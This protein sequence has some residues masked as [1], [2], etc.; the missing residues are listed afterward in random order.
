MK[1]EF[2]NTVALVKPDN[3]GEAEV[4]GQVRDKVKTAVPSARY[5][6]QHKLWLRTKGKQGWDGKTSILSKP[7]PSNRSA[8]FPTGLLPMVH[9]EL[10]ERMNGVI[11][12]KDL[13]VVPPGMDMNPTY[14]VPLRDYQQG[15]ISPAMSNVVVMGEMEHYWPCGVLKIATGGGKTEIAVA[16]YEAQPLPSV[17]VVHRKHLITQA[18]DRF[19]KYGIPSG[20]IGDS[21][22]E[23][24]PTGITVATI[25]TLHKVLKDGDMSKIRQFIKAQQIWFDEAHLCASKVDKGNQFVT[26]A[27]QFRH[28][29]FRW[30][31]T[32]TPFMKDKY[33]NQLLMGCTGDLLCEISNDFLIK[34]GY[35]T[36][37]LVKIIDT[38]DVVG[39]K[40]WPEVY[41]SAIVLNRPRN[42]RIIEE[43]AA[44]PK[45]AI[46]M[47]TRLGHARVLHRMAK[48]KG[49][50]LP[51][52]QCGDTKNKDRT[53]MI[54]D[55]QSGREKAIIAT[56][57]YDDGLDIPE[58]R[59]LIFAGGGKSTVASL[60]RIGRG[61]RLA[62]GKH[63]VLVIDFNDTSGT[64]MKRHSA[65]RRKVWRDEG[66]TIEEVT[67]DDHT[68]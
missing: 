32:A 19:A 53:Q 40:Q 15:A 49:I 27:R 66:F 68:K 38:P 54:K 5:M 17:F 51:A 20:Q 2:D 8:F 12:F 41:E 6:Y 64:I 42:L 7:H 67:A 48:D 35:L 60:Q 50:Q 23:P 28:A 25:Q 3:E 9:D 58:L 10:M 39:P 62:A 36:P 18:R 46:V 57:I 43:L 1:I 61:L 56:T 33:S 24:S 59:T 52:I 22:F 37:P 63:E 16:M 21:V 34:A 26:L 14:T 65:A 29:Y 30:G 31:L 45:P 55:L 47:C 44:C 13:R 4:Y 11:Q